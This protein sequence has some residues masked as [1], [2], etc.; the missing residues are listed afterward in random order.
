[1]I[2]VGSTAT[3][4]GLYETIDCSG[5]PLPRSPNWSGT[6]SYKHVFD[7]PNEANLQVGVDVNFSSSRYTAVDYIAAEHAP[8]YIRE[9][10]DFTYYPAGSAWSFSGF[11]K[12][13]SNKAVVVGG[14]EAALASGLVYNT[15]DAPRTFG[16]RV[17]FNF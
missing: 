2:P 12:N 13:I 15:V 9:N 1:M 16:A 14:V 11:V 5:H 10:S 8:G 17:K 3:A 4:S 7:L 6:A